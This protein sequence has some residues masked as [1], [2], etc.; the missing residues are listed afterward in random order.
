MELLDVKWK[1]VPGYKGLYEASTLGQVR[2]LKVTKKRRM[3]IVDPYMISGYL[4]VELWKNNK[5]K[6]LRLSRIIALTFLKRIKGKDQV[7]HKNGIKYDNRLVNLEW[8]TCE[9]NVHHAMQWGLSTKTYPSKNPDPAFKAQTNE[10]VKV[11][12][13]AANGDF[14][15]V[16]PTIKEAALSANASIAVVFKAVKNENRKAGGYFWREYS[17]EHMC[18]TLDTWGSPEERKTR[19]FWG[20]GV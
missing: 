16:F 12:Q 14:L 1:A 5:S 19:F 11:I 6:Q 3:R 18:C 7:N 15:G 10:N 8:N 13:Y 9:E 17:S 4:Y 2:S 20:A